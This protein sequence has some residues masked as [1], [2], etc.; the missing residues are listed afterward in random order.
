MS[1]RAA[2]GWKIK[3]P[4]QDRLR[5]KGQQSFFQLQQTSCSA[6][7]APRLLVGMHAHPGFGRPEGRDQ[8][9]CKSISS[10]VSSARARFSVDRTGGA[11]ILVH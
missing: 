5:A 3:L 1:L 2:A 6:W 11:R 7:P 4:Q 8:I 10:G 9:L